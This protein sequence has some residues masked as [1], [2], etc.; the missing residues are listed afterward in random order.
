MPSEKVRGIREVVSQTSGKVK[1]FIQEEPNLVAAITLDIVKN[2][3]GSRD[4]L[5][6]HWN[7]Q[8][9]CFYFL[10]QS[11]KDSMKAS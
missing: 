7:C 8:L 5:L 11:N 6:R 1:P 9:L 3:C 2:K 10:F 4:T